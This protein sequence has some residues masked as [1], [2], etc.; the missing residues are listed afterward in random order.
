MRK[1]RGNI[2]VKTTVKTKDHQRLLGIIISQQIGP[3]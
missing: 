1:Q 3:P 2:T